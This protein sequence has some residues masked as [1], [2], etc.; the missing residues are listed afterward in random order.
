MI[1]EGFFNNK[2]SH[3]I[4]EEYLRDPLLEKISALILGCTHYP[5]IKKE[6]SDFY[7][8]NIA[9][10]DSSDVVATAL[11]QYL[12]QAGLLNDQAPGTDHFLVSD[13]TD[14]FEASTKLFFHEAV[15]LEKHPLWN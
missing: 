15:H 7:H 14:S 1:E 3:N 12:S 4:I 10:L 6:I 9:V 5:L 13:F 2:I 11:Y 8:D